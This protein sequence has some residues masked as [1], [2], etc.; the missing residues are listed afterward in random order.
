MGKD[1][2]GPDN[3]WKTF[4]GLKKTSAKEVLENRDR[5]NNEDLK[6]MVGGL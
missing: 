1:G 2:P 3:D 6:R 5:G 4:W